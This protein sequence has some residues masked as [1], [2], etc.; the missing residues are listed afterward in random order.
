MKQE[1]L[2]LREQVE[3]LKSELSAAIQRENELLGIDGGA[4]GLK[5]KLM[6]TKIGKLAAN[7]DSK[8]GKIVRF[9]RVCFRV[10]MH[11]SI[12]KEI[13]AQK[14]KKN[15]NNKKDNQGQKDIFAPIS[16][17]MS[18]YDGMRINLVSGSLNPTLLE[19]ASKVA[20]DNNAELRIITCSESVDP[21]KYKKIVKNNK[22]IPAK[23]VSF[24][25]SVDQN[26]R[27]DVFQLEIGKKDIFITEAWEKGNER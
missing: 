8:I 7:P 13:R 6:R 23:K 10:L 17:F 22:I 18:D 25:S 27:D 3:A 21:I 2:E 24:Y 5:R 4:S 12:I 19:I 20:N 9:P 1:V 15:Q 16:Y 11:P 14:Q 26:A